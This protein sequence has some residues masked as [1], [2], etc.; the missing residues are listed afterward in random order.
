MLKPGQKAQ[1]ADH[2]ARHH[3]IDC[4]VSF[5]WALASGGRV[6]G[7]VVDVEGEW[8]WVEGEDG[9]RRVRKVSRLEAE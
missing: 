3:L 1:I 6:R 2:T 4:R 5:V 8:A 7:T 9:V